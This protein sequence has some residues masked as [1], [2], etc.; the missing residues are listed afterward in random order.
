MSGAQLPNSGDGFT[1]GRYVLA[2]TDAEGARDPI[3]L[4][5]QVK[6]MR[7]GMERALGGRRP[8]LILLVVDD[9]ERHAAVARLKAALETDAC[10]TASEE[11]NHG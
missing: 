11:A 7:D 10:S 9:D 6:F 4:T 1:A 5:Q 8:G 2:D 3:G